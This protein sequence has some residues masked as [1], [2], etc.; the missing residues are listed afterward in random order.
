[1]VFQD[2][3]PFLHLTVYKNIAFGL[4]VRGLPETK[5]E[6]R[7]REVMEL[8]RLPFREFAHRRIAS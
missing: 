3:A 7:V 5:I 6:K 8:I 4:E 1:M 2:L